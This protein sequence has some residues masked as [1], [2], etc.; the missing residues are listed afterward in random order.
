MERLRG[1]D[2][3][4]VHAQQIGHAL[5]QAVGLLQQM[6]CFGRRKGRRRWR[7]EQQIAFVQM[8]HERTADVLQRPQTQHQQHSSDHQ[9]ALG[10]PQHDVQQQPLDS[11][12]Q[13]AQR[14]ALL[15]RNA[16]EDQVRAC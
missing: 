11:N 13:A 6:G 10:R 16:A 12:E 14:I 2:L 1:N 3:R 9:R 5:D 4:A 7:H 8:R 15:V